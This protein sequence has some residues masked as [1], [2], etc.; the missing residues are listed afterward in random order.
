MTAI[1]E[2]MNITKSGLFLYITSLISFYA[3]Y[4]ALPGSCQNAA[5]VQAAINAAVPGKV[6][7]HTPVNFGGLTITDCGNISLD[8]VKPFVKI[9]NLNLVGKTKDCSI[10]MT[11][12]HS[13]VNNLFLINVNVTNGTH[14]VSLG[15]C[16]A[17]PGIASVVFYGNTNTIENSTITGGTASG[18]FLGGSNNVVT[19]NQFNAVNTNNAQKMTSCSGIVVAGFHNLVSF[20][21]IIGSNGSGIHITNDPNASPLAGKAGNHLI[22]G[23]LVQDTL[24]LSFQG[25]PYPNDGGAIYQG[26]NVG[27]ATSIQFNVIKGINPKN[28]KNNAV[29]GGVICAAGLYFDNNT[30]GYVA[31]NNFV[32]V[33]SSYAALKM[34]PQTLTSN[35]GDKLTSGNRVVTGNTFVG[36]PGKAIVGSMKIVL[37]NGSTAVMT[38]PDVPAA[39]SNKIVPVGTKPSFSA[40]VGASLPAPSFLAPLN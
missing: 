32:D 23:N 18:V 29:C 16:G 34:N 24:A 33:G 4:A 17:G 9:M 13:S 7:A 15:G 19:Q 11:E 25:T 14:S 21:S 37:A 35:P 26:W 10:G 27:N 5:C 1:T 40:G 38:S 20:N 36:I 30:S 22:F 31:Q 3:A 12:A 6:G 39:L 28:F 2:K 8:S